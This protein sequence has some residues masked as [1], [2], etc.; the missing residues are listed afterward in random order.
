MTKFNNY[1]LIMAG[2]VGSRFW[3]KSRNLFPK[4]FIDILG[5]GKSLLQLTY[6]RFL[7]I[8]PNEQIFILTNETYADLV[9]EQLPE[10]LKENILLEPSRNNTAPCIA[11][12][13]YKISKLNPDANIIVAPSDHL[14]LKEDIFISKVL[15]ALEFSFENNALLTLGI[16]PTRPDTG[17]GYIRYQKTD[18]TGYDELNGVKKVS[19]FMEKPILA[20]AE[21][22]LKSGDYVWNAGIFIWSANSL[23][24]AFVSHAPEIAALFE[25][26]LPFYNTSD[27]SK[28][29]ADHYPSSPN[30]SIDY[31]IL[32]KADNVYTIPADIGWSDLGTWAS[33]HAVGE[34]D[35]SNNMV[36]LN[37]VNLKDTT[38]CI[39]HLPKEKAAVIKGLDNYIVVDDGE[40]LLIYPKSDEQEIKQ[41]AKNMVDEHG[42]KYA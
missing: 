8:C 30:I 36:N 7:N 13:T 31:A 9:A 28:F 35:T 3:P 33:L 42:I 19:A 29:I 14:I 41:V 40:I 20:K 18:V 37:K 25:S 2:G 23:K 16:S 4:Q 32:E 21:E 22:Y 17:Y 24:K 5:I 39:I 6:E 15:Q 10:V 27:E 26:G 11:Y 38:N 1:V 12:A 34:K